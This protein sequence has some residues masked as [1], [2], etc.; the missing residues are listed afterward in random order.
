MAKSDR[1]DRCGAEANHFAAQGMSS[2]LFC[3]HHKNKYEAKLTEQ[4]FSIFSVSQ[5]ENES[6]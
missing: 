4:G 5:I 3:T 6:T 1:C 2:L